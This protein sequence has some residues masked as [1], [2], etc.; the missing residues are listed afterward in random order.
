LADPVDTLIAGLRS[1]LERELQPHLE[2]IAQLRVTLERY[3][4]AVRRRTEHALVERAAGALGVRLEATQD[5]AFAREEL[6][7][8]VRA[9]PPLVAS[10]SAQHPE[11]TPA[12]VAATPP[13]PEVASPEAVAAWIAAQK[14]EPPPRPSLSAT[15]ERLRQR[16]VLRALLERIGKPRSFSSDVDMIDE[17]DALDEIS[18]GD[19]RARWDKLSRDHQRLWLTHLVAR[20]RHL[21]DRS[22]LNASI[23]ARLRDV[24]VRFPEYASAVRPGHVNG[25]RIDHEPAQGSWERDAQ[26][27]YDELVAQ[28]DEP[29]AATVDDERPSARKSKP[30]KVTDEVSEPIEWKYRERA[31]EMRVVMFGGSRREDARANI[32]AALG[33]GTLEWAEGDKPRRV[34]ALAAAIAR[35]GYDL[36]LLLRSFVHH[37]HADKLIASAKSSGTPF[38]AIDAGYG[39]EAVRAAI[40]GA[41]DADEERARDTG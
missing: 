28:I 16:N 19:E 22:A 7:S 15:D 17:M 10:G 4:A 41:L 24:I 3:E 36:F 9:L 25:M 33:I 2:A 30:S 31:A 34:D 14:A 37:A 39:V 6:E 29:R 35:G 13:T 20:A 38:A 18:S 1:A 21:K 11:P 26:A 8:A 27:T 5:D 40:E 12:T 23:K 32:E